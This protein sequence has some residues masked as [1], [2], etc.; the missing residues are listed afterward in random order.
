MDQQGI[1]PVSLVWS[2]CRSPTLA[3]INPPLRRIVAGLMN[4]TAVGNR[5][6]A[7]NSK[8][9]IVHEAS[10]LRP[11]SNSSTTSYN[12]RALPTRSEWCTD[13]INSWS[14][15]ESIRH[16]I[17]TWHTISPPLSLWN[18]FLQSHN[19]PSLQT[20]KMHLL[21]DFVSAM[22]SLEAVIWCASE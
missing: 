16:V 13:P 2:Y 17:T 1:F 18:C 21:H 15:N 4:P 3:K 5:I 20:I 12:F 11:K 14:I 8:S 19:H 9:S 10:P 22:K 6:Q 7:H